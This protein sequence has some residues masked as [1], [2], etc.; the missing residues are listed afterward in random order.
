MEKENAFV[1]LGNRLFDCMILNFLW[2]LTVIISFG[3]ATGAAN[4]D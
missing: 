2:L 4:M 3:I 1:F